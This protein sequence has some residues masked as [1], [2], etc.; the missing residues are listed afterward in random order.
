[1]PT[2]ALIAGS[3]EHDK[4]ARRNAIEAQLARPNSAST[5]RKGI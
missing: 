1:M 5:Q 2:T 3:I 4:K